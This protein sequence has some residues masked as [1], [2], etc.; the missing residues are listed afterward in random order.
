MD[1]VY[2][3][4]DFQS[5]Y[6][7][8]EAV[9]F[10]THAFDPLS[11]WSAHQVKIWGKTFPTVEHAFQYRKFADA[12]PDIAQQIFDAPSPY[13]AMKI[14][15]KYKD[16]TPGPWREQRI[17]VMTEIIHAKAD[18]HQDFKDCLLATRDKTI[19]ENS[20]WDDFWGCGANQKGQNQMGKILMVVRNSLQK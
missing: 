19:V 1:I 16:K 15:R 7:T 2:P 8:D 4:S 10:F 12:E 17:D 18:Q 14:A 9:Y 5:N 3:D 20:P 11:N 13:L 6:E